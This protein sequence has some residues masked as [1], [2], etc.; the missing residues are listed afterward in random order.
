MYCF[1]VVCYSLQILKMH[2][3]VLEVTHQ[4]FLSSCSQSPEEAEG[5]GVARGT[6]EKA[7]TAAPTLLQ[8][9]PHLG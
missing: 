3:Q 9:P 6:K 4:V 2:M 5:G 7:R 1:I 8:L